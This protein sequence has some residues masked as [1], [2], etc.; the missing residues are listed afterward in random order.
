M[1]ID[2]LKKIALGCISV[3]WLSVSNG[4]ADFLPDTEGVPIIN[5]GAS[6]SYENEPFQPTDL[7]SFSKD[8]DPYAEN[9]EQ[10]K[11]DAFSKKPANPFEWW[12]E[13]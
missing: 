9:A 12:I 2:Y 8:S 5:D 13:V 6:M 3:L 11:V 10:E 4:T 1:H 7:D